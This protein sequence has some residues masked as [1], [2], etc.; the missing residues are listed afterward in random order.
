VRA[1]LS[2]LKA[3]LGWPEVARPR[4]HAGLALAALAGTLLA[5]G[6]VGR[7]KFGS[8]SILPPFERHVVYRE[9][10][11]LARIGGGAFHLSN[12]PTGLYNYL[13]PGSVTYPRT[14]PWIG[15][16]TDVSLFPGAFVDDIEHFLGLPHLMGAL[17]LL[18]GVGVGSLRRTVPAR[19]ALPVAVALALS[20]VPLFA[21]IALCGRYLYD[22]YPPLAAAAAMGLAA[23]HRSP[24]PRLQAAVR[25]LAVYNLAVGLALAFAIQ[26]DLGQTVRRAGLQA[27]AAEVDALTGSR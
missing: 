5:L 27:I 15:P 6:A 10:Q 8:W 23:L 24:R 1:R 17:L 7:A 19:A 26:R 2:R 25:A 11:R 3:W 9:P 4:A 21:F 14:F 13:S 12:L 20:A 18:A 22:F 16:S